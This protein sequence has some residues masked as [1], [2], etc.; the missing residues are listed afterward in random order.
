MR[1][2]PAARLGDCGG[3]GAIVG[4]D[5]LEAAVEHAALHLAA[6]P[7]QRRRGDLPRQARDS[8]TASPAA[9]AQRVQLE[10]LQCS[11]LTHRLLPFVMPPFG[12]PPC[13]TPETGFQQL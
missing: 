11:W 1:R 4:G 5:R 7:G 9:G 8:R 3:Q 10:T 13:D 2:A 12:L 6:L